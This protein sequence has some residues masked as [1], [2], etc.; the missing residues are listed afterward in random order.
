MLRSLRLIE[1]N[2]HARRTPRDLP[3][4]PHA[5][6]L[7][8]AVRLSF[9]LHVV[10]VVVLAPRTDEEAGAEQGSRRCADF[11]DLGDGVGEGSRVHKDLLVESVRT[12][13]VLQLR[14][15]GRQQDIPGL[16]GRHVGR[17]MGL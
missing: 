5:I 9:A 6:Q 12:L 13:S 11:L 3:A 8:P 15:V 2:I 17:A 4:L 14:V 1:D 16:S 7:S 10:I